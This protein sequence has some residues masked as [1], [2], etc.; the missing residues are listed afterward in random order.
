V[1]CIEA[2]QLNNTIGPES[3]AVRHSFSNGTGLFFHFHDEVVINAGGEFNLNFFFLNTL[4]LFLFDFILLTQSY[5][6]TI[7]N[8]VEMACIFLEHRCIAC[9]NLKSVF[10]TAD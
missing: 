4:Q 3:A 10:T 9:N 7:F 2:T 1:A 6:F 8:V 5:N